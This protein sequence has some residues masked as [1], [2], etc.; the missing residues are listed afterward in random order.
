M[1]RYLLRL[2][3]AVALVAVGFYACQLNPPPCRAMQMPAAPNLSVTRVQDNQAQAA[4]PKPP[5][6]VVG[7]IAFLDKSGAIVGEHSGAF[8]S[9]E[10]C[11]KVAQ[12]AIA[13]DMTN[14]PEL[15]GTKAI[16]SCWDT[17]DVKSNRKAPPNDSEVLYLVPKASKEPL[18]PYPFY[19]DDRQVQ[20]T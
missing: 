8:T 18:S 15:A 12:K 14:T 20:T 9:V 13:D 19:H 5:L 10:V 6:Y 2:L 1:R 17:R 7:M 11:A 16:V 4:Q 3:A